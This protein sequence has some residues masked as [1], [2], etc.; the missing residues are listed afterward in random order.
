MSDEERPAKRQKV[1][2]ININ[3]AL[4]K[5]HEVKALSE[6]GSLHVSA[7]QGLAERADEIL[8]E[9]KIKTIRDFANWKFANWAKAIV[10]LAETEEEGRRS[11]QCKMNINHAVD[12]EHH[13]KSLNEI[14][15]LPVSALKGI[16]ENG[17][18]LL[19]G[20]H[21]KTVRDFGGWKYVKWSKAILALSELEEGSKPSRGRKKK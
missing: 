4:D 1:T 15:A 12:K 14:C 20:L 2:G 5:E 19:E 8:K 17:A 9:F 11:D 7:L 21:V 16:S 18:K 6:L 3:N 10:D 13:D